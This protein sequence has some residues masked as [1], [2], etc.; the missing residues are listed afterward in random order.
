M[1]FRTLKRSPIIPQS[2]SSTKKFP[3]DAK[4]ATS[5]NSSSICSSSDSDSEAEPDA[6]TMEKVQKNKAVVYW[7]SYAEKKQRVLMFTQDEETFLK[8]KSLVDPESSKNEIF[9]AI[10]GVGL[11][12]VADSQT[13]NQH[14]RELAYASIT[15]SA[16][17]WELDAGKRWKA[18]TL[19]LNA[20][21]EDK[22]K[23][24]PTQA[25]FNNFIDVNFSKMHM[26]KPFF[27]KLRRTYS[28][29]I[30]IHL[31]KSNSLTY[32]QGNIH[33]IQIDNQIQD[34]IFPIILRPGSKK[35][36]SNNLGIPKLKHCIEFFFLKQVKPTHDVYKKINLIIREFHLNLQ[37][38]FFIRLINDLLPKK[39]NETKHSLASRLKTDLFNVYVPLPC[40]PEK[41]QTNKKRCNVVELLY[42]APIK[43]HVKFLA[44]A[45]ARIVHYDPTDYCNIVR[46]LFEYASKGTFLKYAEFRLPHYEKIDATI[47]SEEWLI[48][49]WKNFKDELRHQFNVLI[50]SMTVLGN[51]YSYNFKSPGDSFY[52]TDTVSF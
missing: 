28:P 34:S 48:D 18:L 32:V 50:L 10:A 6:P 45:D 36:F 3:N 41:Q 13:P 31:R 47:N 40:L 26:T 19:E 8:A 33:R 22:Y 20:W 51:P 11:S 12:I 49:A 35:C 30:W 42:I 29:G 23:N 37:E 17:H 7:I 39:R 52:D 25:Q 27:A 14:S 9:L 38:E 44:S 15:D 16:A 21:M 4:F 1:T 5:V 24:T 2:S 46:P 43:L